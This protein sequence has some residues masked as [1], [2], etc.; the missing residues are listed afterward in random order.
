LVALT[1]KLAIFGLLLLLGAVNLL[2]LS[3][4]L[5]RAVARALHWLRRSVPTEI[6]L[7]SCAL[8]TAGV[9]TTVS[10]SID[11]L[12]AQHNL[13]FEQSV[14]ESSVRMVLRIAPARVGVDVS[15][16][17]PGAAG[18]TPTVLLRFTMVD[19]DTTTQVEATHLQGVRYTARGSYL[20]MS[21]HW[22]VEVILPPRL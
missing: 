12:T 20:S 8:L 16:R 18:A 4:Q 17:R 22:Q 2:L 14:K 1:I 7:G 5:R 10:P 15:D 6:T 19:R 21:G 9:L 3:P 11:E 13:G